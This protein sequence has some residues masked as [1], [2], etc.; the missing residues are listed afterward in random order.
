MVREFAQLYLTL[1]LATRGKQEY[2]VESLSGRKATHRFPLHQSPAGN[3]LPQPPPARK[4]LQPDGVSRFS[5]LILSEISA[6]MRA[7]VSLSHGTPDSLACNKNCCLSSISFATF[8]V[9]FLPV[10]D[11]GREGRKNSAEERPEEDWPVFYSTRFRL[12]RDG[13]IIIKEHHSPEKDPNGNNFSSFFLIHACP[14]T[15]YRKP[16]T[17]YRK[18]QGVKG[19]PGDSERTGRR[20]SRACLSYTRFRLERDGR[21]IK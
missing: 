9:L 6:K 17:L 4:S 15:L 5:S 16:H 11:A 13:R 12:E 19:G 2:L 18:F 1:Q 21:M 10:N 7:S 14:H 20:L 3:P 8:V